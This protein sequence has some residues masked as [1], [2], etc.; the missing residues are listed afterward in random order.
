MRRDDSRNVLLSAVRITDGRLR[1]R[2]N[3]GLYPEGSNLNGT[4]R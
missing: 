3:V 2:E 4:E 1:C